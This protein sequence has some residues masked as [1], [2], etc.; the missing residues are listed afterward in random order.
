MSRALNRDQC[1]ITVCLAASTGGKRGRVHPG[2]HRLAAEKLLGRWH[3][4]LHRPGVNHQINICCWL[5]MDRRE[6]RRDGERA[7]EGVTHT[8]INHQI[9][10]VSDR[11][12]SHKHGRAR[13]ANIP[14][15][16]VGWVD[17]CRCS[18]GRKQRDYLCLCLEDVNV[19][20]VWDL[21][22][23]GFFCIRSCGSPD[24][25]ACVQWQRRWHRAG[26]VSSRSSVQRLL[27]GG[28]MQLWAAVWG[29][30]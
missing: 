22:M 10:G 1:V 8:V 9:S 19:C 5:R 21:V 7:G 24:L 3:P 25:P 6:E 30:A 17:V 23:F 28:L 29:W 15:Q 4:G 20:G 2:N 11:L 16:F 12:L 13:T 26:V 27:H 18:S 14:P